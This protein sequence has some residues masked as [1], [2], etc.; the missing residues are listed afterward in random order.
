MVPKVSKHCFTR[1][2]SARCRFY[3]RLPL[4]F[5]AKTLYTIIHRRKGLNFHSL[6]LP[7]WGFSSY[8][9][10]KGVAILQKQKVTTLQPQTQSVRR[11]QQMSEICTIWYN[12]YSH[13]HPPS[14]CNWWNSLIDSYNIRCDVEWNAGCHVSH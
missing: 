1:L 2:I 4:F 3:H 11:Q 7:W 6:L 8:Y 14:Q 5:H 12:H 13:P 10:S 9:F